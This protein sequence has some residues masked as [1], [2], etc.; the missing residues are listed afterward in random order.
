MLDFEENVLK[1]DN[2]IHSI[3]VDI[4]LKETKKKNEELKKEITR[5]KE[6][7]SALKCKGNKVLESYEIKEITMESLKK[8]IKALKEDCTKAM[9]KEDAVIQNLKKEKKKKKKKKKC[10]IYLKA[11]CT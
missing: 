4:K 11:Y 7:I 10:N 3:V 8:H 9:S 1:D 6:E 2:I 5:L